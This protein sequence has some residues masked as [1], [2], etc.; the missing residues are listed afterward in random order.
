MEK[1]NYI[2]PEVEV[3]EVEIEKGFA[4]SSMEGIGKNPTLDW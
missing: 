1:Q 3:I 2:T 4:A